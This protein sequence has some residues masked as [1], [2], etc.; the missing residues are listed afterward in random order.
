MFE[1]P[2]ATP[3]TNPVE[4]ITVATDVFPEVH[5]PPEDAS[6][7]VVVLPTHTDV[8]PVMAPAEGRGFTVTTFVADAVP[9]LAV[10][11]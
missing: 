7:S 3:V 1:V 11:V 2:T 9:Q 5:V 10:L 4:E 8:V 6:V